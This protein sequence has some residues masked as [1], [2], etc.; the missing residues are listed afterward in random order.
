MRV[1]D[2]QQVGLVRETGAVDS[3]CCWTAVMLWDLRYVPRSVIGLTRRRL[4]E[5][6]VGTSVIVLI[7]RKAMVSAGLLSQSVA[8]VLRLS[9]SEVPDASNV[10]NI[11][12]TNDGPRRHALHAYARFDAELLGL[13]RS[14]LLHPWRTE[15]RWSRN[16][17]QLNLRN[18]QIQP[19]YSLCSVLRLGLMLW[20]NKSA[21]ALRKSL[22]H[23]RCVG[24]LRSDGGASED[25]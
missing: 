17:T 2:V 7:D 12:R 24:L 25:P 11:C 10:N 21:R 13:K 3:W 22:Y 20:Q 1:T 15:T 18:K 6:T 23:G 14:R 19:R 5:S 9:S 8:F 4:I 16:V